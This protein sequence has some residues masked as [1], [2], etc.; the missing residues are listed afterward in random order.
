MVC[1]LLKEW[2]DMPGLLHS[3]AFIFT[4]VFI[5]N[6]NSCH[7]LRNNKQNTE[8]KPQRRWNKMTSAKSVT[9][10]TIV[11]THVPSPAT[12]SVMSLLGPTKIWITILSNRTYIK[13]KHYNMLEWLMSK[14]GF[15]R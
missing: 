7:L 11:P 3:L 15:L 9:I 2:R 8:R 6:I 12:A 1:N 13:K 5:N 10:I 4:H 14:V